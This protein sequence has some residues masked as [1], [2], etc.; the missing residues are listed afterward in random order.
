MTKKHA[1]ATER[2]A[3]VERLRKQA[4][5]QARVNAIAIRDATFT[6]AVNSALFDVAG[7]A[8]KLLQ[9]RMPRGASYLLSALQ[10]IQSEFEEQRLQ[11]AAGQHKRSEP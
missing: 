2:T 3:E 11:A 1:P 10:M 7:A 8:E 4:E 9:V 6:S 5:N